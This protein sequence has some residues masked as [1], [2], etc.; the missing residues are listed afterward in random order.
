LV[1]I[2]TNFRKQ[3][4]NDEKTNDDRSQYYLNASNGI[5]INVWYDEFS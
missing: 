1:K 4:T 2:Q 3:K 5:V